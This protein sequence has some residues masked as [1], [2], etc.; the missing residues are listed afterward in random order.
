MDFDTVNL[1]TSNVNRRV[2]KKFL[3]VSRKSEIGLRVCV[4][5]L[6]F[7]HVDNLIPDWLF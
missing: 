3:L 7:R 1:F 5:L 6:N 4:R 2:S